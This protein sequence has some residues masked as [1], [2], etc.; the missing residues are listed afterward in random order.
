MGAFLGSIS[1]VQFRSRNKWH[2]GNLANATGGMYLW[3][4][5]VSRDL[6]NEKI[7]LYLTKWDLHKKRHPG[8]GLQKNKMTRGVVGE[9]AVME[10]N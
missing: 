5:I 7:V 2:W 4:G 1:L 9:V 6:M 10:Q 3:S 8:R